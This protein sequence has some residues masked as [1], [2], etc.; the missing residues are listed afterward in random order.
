MEVTV[1]GGKVRN[2]DFRPASMDETVAEVD[3][4]DDNLSVLP[5]SL[6]AKR[7]L[8]AQRRSP[9]YSRD[10]RNLQLHESNFV[11]SDEGFKME[12]STPRHF[13]FDDQAFNSELEKSGPSSPASDTQP[14]LNRSNALGSVTFSCP[15]C[16]CK[17]YVGVGT[18]DSPAAR[19]N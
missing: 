6:V 12:T 1:N 16:S 5:N 4:N 13:N 18:T 19:K 15:N 7:R 2:K 9:R 17:M 3:D 10:M 11:T 14:R 8:T